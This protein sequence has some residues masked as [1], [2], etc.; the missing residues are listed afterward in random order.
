MDINFRQLRAFTLIAQTLSFTR[1]SELLHLSPPALSYSIRK[2]EESLGLKL[3]ARN[4]RSVELTPAGEHF[5]PQAQ[6]LLRLMGD[7][8]S[9]AQD[10][11]NLDSGTLRLAA[12]P[13]AAASFLPR[14]IAS[15]SRDH[16]GVQ[17]SL[18]DGRAG[19]VR[20]W[21]LTGEVDVGVTS[22]PED[23]LGLEF[24]HLVND[25]L[26]LLVRD[27]GESWKT[28]P[29]IAL[30]TDTSIR[31][32]ADM[33]LHHLGVSA[34]PSWQVSHMSTAAAMVREGLG[35]SLLPASCALFLHLGEGLLVLPVEQPGQRALGLLQRKPVRQSPAMQMFL[36]YLDNGLNQT[37]T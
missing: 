2:L 8:V 1:T 31:P 11:L 24:K 33:T 37:P 26:V 20:D 32:L 28:K 4:T 27:D 36:H 12:L 35:F 9:D 15:F 10:L 6:Q 17:V 3:L 25:D 34:H 18:L 7:A 13:T 16:P 29:Y 30:T 5:L 22:L 23:M 14:A 21:V 19:E